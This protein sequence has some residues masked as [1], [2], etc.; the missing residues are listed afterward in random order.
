[1]IDNSQNKMVNK[2]SLQMNERCPVIPRTTANSPFFNQSGSQY[3]SRAGIFKARRQTI[4]YGIIQEQLQNQQEDASQIIG[5]ERPTP[6]MQLRDQKYHRCTQNNSPNKIVLPS[7][8]GQA[9]SM[10]KNYQNQM[11]S[12]QAAPRSVSSLKARSK[13]ESSEVP[14]MIQIIVPEGMQGQ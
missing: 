8:N 12:S 9:L 11:P 5:D 3:P 14:Q 2:K 13:L 1:M 10:I 4:G 7:Q 6:Y